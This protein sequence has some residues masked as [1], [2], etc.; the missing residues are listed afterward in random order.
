MQNQTDVV[1]LQLGVNDALALVLPKDKEFLK[2]IEFEITIPQVAVYYRGAIVWSLYNKVTPLPAED[3][4]DYNADKVYQDIFPGTLSYNFKV[5]II[6][7]HNLES[8][9]YTVLLPKLY[10]KEADLMFM[11]FQLAMKGSSADLYNALFTVQVKPV[12]FDEG[13]FVL[14]LQYP[15]SNTL[16]NNESFLEGA[17][18]IYI[19]GEAVGEV[20]KGESVKPIRLSTGTHHLSII[21]DFY[22]NEVRTF[23]IDQAGTSNVFVKLRDVTPFITISAPSS[24]KVYLDDNELLLDNTELYVRPGEHTIRFIIGDYELI[25]SFTVENGKSYTLGVTMDVDILEEK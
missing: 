9:P 20:Q 5:P 2:G 22:R 6:E 18:V 19:D 15:E 21:S 10:T 4:I 1:E 13:L 24:S 17:S 23:T 12:L 11:R 16:D 25:K 8:S 7:N 14:D 3:V